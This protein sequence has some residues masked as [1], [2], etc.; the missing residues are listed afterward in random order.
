MRTASGLSVS[1]NGRATG[2]VKR[3]SACGRGFV[4]LMLASNARR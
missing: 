2:I 4:L 3:P 1:G